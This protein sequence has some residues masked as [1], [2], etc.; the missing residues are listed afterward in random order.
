MLQ[1]KISSD[2]R[3]TF[4]GSIDEVRHTWEIRKVDSLDFHE[5]TKIVEGVIGQ[6]VFGYQSAD[7]LREIVRDY[8][9]DTQ[10]TMGDLLNG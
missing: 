8:M 3:R 7:D 6:E 4:Q 5:L 10:A 1:G 9:N 2:N